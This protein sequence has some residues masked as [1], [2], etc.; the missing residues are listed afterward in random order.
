MGSV[1]T[2]TKSTTTATSSVILS[3]KTG[4][5][6]ADADDDD[7]DRNVQ[8]GFTDL[9]QNSGNDEPVGV[10]GRESGDVVVVHV[11]E[12]NDDQHKQ[13]HHHRRNGHHHNTSSELHSSDDGSAHLTVGNGSI[14]PRSAKRHSG[15][16][17]GVASSVAD[18][19]YDQFET[20]TANYDSMSESS[21]VRS[22]FSFSSNAVNGNGVRD[23]RN[24]RREQMDIDGTCSMM[25]TGSFQASDE[26]DLENSQM[27]QRKL[28][29]IRE[30]QQKLKT[31]GVAD[32]AACATSAKTTDPKAPES[33]RTLQN[34]LNHHS[35]SHPLAPPATDSRNRTSTPASSL[36]DEHT[37]HSRKS[38]RSVQNSNNNNINNNSNT[39]TN[40]TQSNSY[41]HPSA[42]TAPSSAT[43]RLAP[44]TSP[45]SVAP[46]KFELRR[47][48]DREEPEPVPAASEYTTGHRTDGTDGPGSEAKLT[49][50]SVNENLKI[51]S[52]MVQERKAR[53]AAVSAPALHTLR[54][55]GQSTPL[56]HSQSTARLKDREK[57]MRSARSER[58]RFS[59]RNNAGGG[60]ALDGGGVGTPSATLGRGNSGIG[61]DRVDR[62]D[63]ADGAE[64]GS[65]ARRIKRKPKVL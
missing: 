3:P 13:A 25:S 55:G 26:H 49:V 44:T 43:N 32:G 56:S 29:V 9:L 63:G 37:L 61:F 28:T 52:R 64:R 11:P 8:K 57:S 24:R 5:A 7:E 34:S 45:V 10:G 2:C 12:S 39:H 17:A 59:R 20:S 23:E 14:S 27:V 22:N 46:L 35:T 50:R 58:T 18:S 48:L 4:P 51:L 1:C 30:A 16:T 19:G 6:A 41:A 65:I 54:A 53:L 62:S 36:G 60:G 31:S 33:P 40:L 38:T 47:W 15:S 21:D 42:H